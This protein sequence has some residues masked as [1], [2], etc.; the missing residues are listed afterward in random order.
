MTVKRFNFVGGYLY[1]GNKPIG[2][3]EDITFRQDFEDIVN[4]LH[5]ENQSLKQSF[6]LINK[7]R[8]ELIEENEKLKQQNK[9]L[10]SELYIFKEVLI[11]STKFINKLNDE[12][13][14]LKQQLSNVRTLYKSTDDNLFACRETNNELREGYSKLEEENEQ[15][16]KLLILIADADSA[17]S[18]NSVK[19][20]LRNT[21]F[22][23][24]TVAGESYNAF[25]EYSI[26]NKFFKEHYKE[27]W[28]N[29]KYD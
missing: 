16:T 20:I 11:H 5:E 19:E 21:L 18:E 17:R 8:K 14:Q 9:G 7:V 23:L 29:D 24:D 25:K 15:L 13:E 12:N 26:L 3:V 27:H 4:A 6:D 28:D 1:D 10:Q 22:G 2:H